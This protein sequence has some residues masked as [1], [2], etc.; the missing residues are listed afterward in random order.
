MDL[1]SK[2]I[3]LAKRLCFYYVY[4][5]VRIII[6]TLMLLWVFVFKIKALK[7]VLVQNPPSIPVLMVLW[8]AS[9]LKGFEVVVDFHNYGY[10]ILEMNVKNRLVIALAKQYEKFFARRCHKHLCVSSN[11]RKDLKTSWDINATELMDR[12]VRRST[13]T[14]G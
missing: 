11:M 14:L 2:L 5:L 7:F 6:Q 8:L 12:P 3:C 13:I 9:L 1:S 4:I 10:T